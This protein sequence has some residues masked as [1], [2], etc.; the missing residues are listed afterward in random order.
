MMVHRVVPEW[1]AT[2]AKIEEGLDA[3]KLVARHVRC[4]DKRQDIEI[5][6]GPLAE[7]A[8]GKFAA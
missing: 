8:L 2:V 7:A 5:P 4:M 3:D 6:R 1:S